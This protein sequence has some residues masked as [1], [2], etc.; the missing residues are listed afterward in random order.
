[1]RTLLERERRGEVGKLEYGLLFSLLEMVPDLPR[2]SLERT[3]SGLLENLSPTDTTQL[4]RLAR[5]Y[6]KSGFGEKAGTIYR[7]CGV[8]QP[9]RSFS[10]WSSANDLLGE[11]IE[12]LEGDE[13]IRTVEAV[14][15]LSDPGEDAY[16]GREYY[17][18]LVLETWVKL[19]GSERALEKARSICENTTELGNS[20]KRD[21][22]RLAA[23]L[24]AQAGEID[25]ALDCLEVA[26]CTLEAPD[27]LQYSWF[28]SRFENPG[29]L[30]RET[31]KKLF[32]LDSAEG[33]DA[34]AWYDALA[35]RLH[36]WNKAERLR[37]NVA[38]ELLAL[39]AIR[40][41]ESGEVDSA[42]HWLSVVEEGVGTSANQAL[43]LADLHRKFGEE[44]PAT[45]I[46]RR[47]LEEGRLHLGRLAEVVERVRE[48]EGAERALSLAEPVGAYVLETEFLDA[49][50]ESAGAAENPARVARWTELRGAAEAAREELEKRD[51]EAEEEAR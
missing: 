15:A 16:W 32:P 38:F 31:Q 4:R 45:A 29:W 11:V 33:P 10:Y 50:I 34:G 43:W 35:T 46:E 5:L 9:D 3:L 2:E 27:D 6:A 20:P 23:L 12:E 40:L 25:A 30:D 42:A 37:E 17:E 19:L 47:L 24:Y 51:R 26:L 7:W 13:R 41:H 18:T 8:V 49:I 22:A 14:L 28:R 48:S 39:C 44:A 1:M 21:A 36:E